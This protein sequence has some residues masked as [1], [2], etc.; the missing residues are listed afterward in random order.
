[1]NKQ[2]TAGLDIQT[3]HDC[4]GDRR[5]EDAMLSRGMLDQFLAQGK[6]AFIRFTCEAREICFGTPSSEETGK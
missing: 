4:H 5:A 6:P 1:S 3:C 2:P